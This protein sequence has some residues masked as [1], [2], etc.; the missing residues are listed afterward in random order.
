[1]HRIHEQPWGPRKQKHFHFPLG[2]RLWAGPQK[3]KTLVHLSSAPCTVCGHAEPLAAQVDHAHTRTIDTARTHTQEAQLFL[4]TH[5][6][7]PGLV[8][9]NLSVCQS[10]CHPWID[11][12]DVVSTITFL[13]NWRSTDLPSLPSTNERHVVGFSTHHSPPV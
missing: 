6:F 1:M 8:Q 12:R 10:P 5:I 3:T 4:N 2:P 7:P 9:D 13:I 11:W